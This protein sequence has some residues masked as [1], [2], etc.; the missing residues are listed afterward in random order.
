MIESQLVHRQA[1]SAMVEDYERRQGLHWYETELLNR[2]GERV[3]EPRLVHVLGCGAGREMT[4]ICNRFPEA[5]IVGSDISEAMAAATR[6]AVGG[7]PDW[8][9]RTTVL[10]SSI[11]ELTG[12]ADADLVIAFNSVFTCITPEEE[13]MHSLRAVRNL[14]RPDGLFL[15]V[16]HHR[17]GKLLK[18]GYFA[19]QQLVAPLRLAGL[20]GDRLGKIGGAPA[21][22]HYFTRAELRRVL[23][24]ARLEPLEV[25]SISTLAKATGQPY[26]LIRGD[27]NLLAI[28]RA[29]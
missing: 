3:P 22:F 12:P 10:T 7:M 6:R 5:R 24:L 27:N 21:P 4:A 19:L 29:C 2:A 23:S 25:H 18:S 11:A 9:G 17:W 20:P 26:D 1:W 13:R 8:A 14:L 15:I 16:V 28:A